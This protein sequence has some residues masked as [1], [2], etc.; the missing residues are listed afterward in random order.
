MQ[1]QLAKALV[2]DEADLATVWRRRTPQKAMRLL[3]RFPAARMML[4]RTM[5]DVAH[6]WG[7]PQHEAT[8]HLSES[9][10]DKTFRMVYD[11]SRHLR[12]TGRMDDGRM[13]WIWWAA[14]NRSP[15]AVDFMISELEWRAARPTEPHPA[16][17]WRLVA[18]WRKEHRRSPPWM[19]V[20][21][22]REA[23]AALGPNASPSSQQREPQCADNWIRVV[24]EVAGG[25]RHGDQVVAQYGD[26]CRPMALRRLPAGHAVLREVLLAEFP[27]M[28]EAVEAVLADCVLREA[29]GVSSFTFRPLLLVGPAGTGKTRFA[30]RLAE[31]CGTGFG[32][33][34]AAGSNDNRSL[35]GTARGW[36]SAQPCLPLMVMKAAM[37]ANPI[38]LVDEV[39]KAGASQNGDLRATLLTMLEPLSAKA[40]FDE[41]LMAPANL[42]HISWVLTANSLKGIPGPLLSRVRVVAVGQPRPEHFDCILA[43]IHRDLAIDLGVSVSDLPYWSPEVVDALRTA[44][45][46]GASVR[47]LKAASTR[48]LSLTGR[49]MVLH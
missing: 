39:D 42:S 2:E 4:L 36:T 15:L 6:E 14:L 49:D 23:A 30:Q 17:L 48:T 45:I 18:A 32:L 28:E 21:R 3:A 19:A 20:E 5:A 40:W 7:V 38:I 26:L 35:A 25:G 11:N 47:K 43:G 1:T 27:W 33:V 16:R 24:Q 31:L 34:N 12:R 13:L 41:C 9:E 8:A 29:A 44:F 37:T 46:R 22:W 10:P